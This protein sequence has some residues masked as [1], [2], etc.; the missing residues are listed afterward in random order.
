MKEVNRQVP[1]VFQVLNEF[2]DRFMRVKIWLMHTGHNYNGSVFSKEYVEK[3]IPSLAN[4]PILGYIEDNGVQEDYTDHRMVLVRK[5]GDIDVKYIGQA[6]GVIP[7]DNNAQF[8]VRVGDDGVSREYLTC[9]GLLWQKWDTPT[10]IMN[11]D[12]VKS[13][14]MEVH[15]DYEGIWD[16]QG[17]FHFTNFKFFGACI[18]GSGVSPAMNSATIEREFAVGSLQKEIN[19]KVEE[20]K[21]A[22]SRY[23]QSLEDGTNTTTEQEGDDMQ[24]KLLELLAKYSLTEEGIQAKGFK[25]E[26][27]TSEDE[28]DA[29]LAEFA[30]EEAPA[31]VVEPDVTPDPE[32]DNNSIDF[33]AQAEAL[34]TQLTTLQGEFETLNAEFEALKKAN[35][36]LETEAQELRSY[37]SAKLADERQAQEDELFE[38]FAEQ[39]SEDE[40]KEVK[41]VASNME[42]ADI[43]KELF[44]I[45]GKKNAKFSRK[46]KQPTNVKVD[47]TKPK[48]TDVSDYSYILEKHLK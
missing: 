42:I 21:V 11:R 3:A 6:Y 34:N 30:G 17:L 5:D 46:E 29:K 8:E 7:Q 13:Q 28:L 43:E 47:F 41:A 36:D 15:H 26:D 38:Q 25:L 37:K 19:A 44:A 10:E 20:F 16:N 40:M 27:Y 31:A 9:E 35:T 45:V 24:E 32:P 22:Y 18:L 48:E 14:S 12:L 4:T 1:V 2:D 23:Q 39:L 33:A